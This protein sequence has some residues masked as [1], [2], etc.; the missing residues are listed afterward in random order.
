ME[1]FPRAIETSKVES[2][3]SNHTNGKTFQFNL[4]SKV[5]DGIQPDFDWLTVAMTQFNF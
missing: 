3:I 2:K 1:N 4:I 5:S